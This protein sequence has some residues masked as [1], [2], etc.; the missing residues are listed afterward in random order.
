[1]MIHDPKEREYYLSEASSQ[2]WSIVLVPMPTSLLL[3]C[4]V[5]ITKGSIPSTLRRLCIDHGSTFH[6]CPG[7][8]KWSESRAKLEDDEG[9]LFHFHSIGAQE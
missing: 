8:E 6:H 3:T 5:C 4:E 2:K 7:E 9:L 1:M